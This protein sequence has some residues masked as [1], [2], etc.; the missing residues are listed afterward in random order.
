MTKSSPV[1]S[2]DELRRSFVGRHALAGVSFT[3][4][5]GATVILGPNGAGKSTLVRILATADVP[6]GGS[7]EINGTSALSRRGRRVARRHLGWLPQ[8]FGYDPRSR[9]VDYLDYIAWLR[10]IPRQQ[11]PDAIQQSLTRV[12]LA[13]RAGSRFRT[14]SGGM[15]RRVGLAQATLGNPG[16][17]L[18][19]EPTAGLDPIQR[20]SLYRLIRHE[21]E[22]RSVV[23]ATHL[24]EDVDEIAD[25]VVVLA[26]GAVAWSGSIDDLRA[27]SQTQSLARTIVDLMSADGP[28]GAAG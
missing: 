8:Q 7:Y 24:T 26:S 18:L 19:D 2:V 15:I 13:D 22:S 3:A 4:E 10:E 1:V 12:G 6:D 25:R 27:L 21:A 14:L 5:R 28:G 20:Q 16:L 9:V 23:I 11:R 17:L